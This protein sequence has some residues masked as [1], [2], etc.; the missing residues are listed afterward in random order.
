MNILASQWDELAN[1][2]RVSFLQRDA[3]YKL[4]QRNSEVIPYGIPMVQG[5][6]SSIPPPAY[7]SGNCDD[8]N[9]FKVCVI[10]SGLWVGHPDIPF[11]LTSDAI[12]GEEFAIDSPWYRPTASSYHGTHVTGIILAQGNN[13]IGVVGVVPE[14]E[15]ICLLIARTF[16]EQLDQDGS[17][18]TEAVEW[19][20]EKGARVINMSL[21]INETMSPSDA[22]VY[23]QLVNNE[24]IL[25]IAAAGN[26][27]DNTYSYPAS[28]PVVMSVAATTQNY[29]KASFSQFNEQVDIAA[30]GVHI[31]STTIS[32]AAVLSTPNM[33]LDSA[34][35]EFSPDT[36]DILVNVPLQMI[37]CQQGFDV[38]TGATSKACIIERGT[39]PFSEKALNCQKGG[40]LVAFIYNTVDELYGGS[41]LTND[42]GV[43]IPTF[44]LPLS[45]GMVML[46]NVNISTVSLQAA[47][48]SY[49]YL[50][51]TSMSA[52]HVTGVATKIWA[53]RPNCTNLQI[54]E[55]LENSAM[56]LGPNGWDQSSGVGLVQASAAY[57]YILE[58]FDSPCG[59]RDI[60]NS[61]TRS[62]LSI[63]AACTS[64]DACCSGRC[65]PLTLNG[66]TMCRTA[67]QDTRNKMEPLRGG[68]AAMAVRSTTNNDLNGGGRRRRLDKPP[69]IR[70]AGSYQEF[71]KGSS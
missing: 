37:D 43:R 24:D 68:A 49:G 51:G 3:R 34:L 42:T 54:R 58:N 38:C 32:N 65:A 66:P 12:V 53:A 61:N 19:C 41:L 57:R 55:A 64:N 67:S 50:D 31:L 1:D 21:G 30:P 59:E 23:E 25:V 8:P 40:G 46:E 33:V 22:Q 28:L 27:G 26:Q 10:D 2:P 9:S 71:Q 56:D 52:P 13:G 18:I 7:P 62:C 60:S 69:R 48:A 16:D 14:P 15:G 35:M 45:D 29:T 39:I 70:G 11:N 44:A 36:S 5:T 17:V 4:Y 20:A 47:A 6:T 63:Y